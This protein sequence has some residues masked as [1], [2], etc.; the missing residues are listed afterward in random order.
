MADHVPAALRAL[1][2]EAFVT[3]RGRLE[4]G[5]P[6][7]GQ[8]VEA[9]M[10]GLTRGAPAEDYYLRPSAFPMLLLPWWLEASIG[11]ELDR[12]FQGNLVYSTVCGYYVVRMVDDLMDGDRPPPAAVLPAIVV[13]HT[14]FLRTLQSSFGAD[15]PFWDAL[16]TG[17]RLSSETASADAGLASIDRAAF[18]QTSARKTSGARIPLAAVAHRYGRTDLVPP[19]ARLVDALGCW[20]QMLND[21][22]GWHGDLAAGRATYF[23]SEGERCRGHDRSTSEWVVSEGL[24]WGLAELSGWMRELLEVAETLGTPELVAYLRDRQ[25]LIDAEWDE[26]AAGLPAL[27]RLAR[28]LR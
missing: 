23:L 27:E 15:H 14:E 21:L 12:T 26:L 7:L 9:W 5:T 6:V 18:V 28:A 17:S 16:E 8:H 19:W 10:T 13:L 3:L 24:A 2:G 22:R 20:H 1:V 25:A 11:G 4:S